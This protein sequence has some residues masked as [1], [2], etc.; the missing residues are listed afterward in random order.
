MAGNAGHAGSPTSAAREI[1]GFKSLSINLVSAFHVRS[2]LSGSS[3]LQQ[4]PRHGWLGALT[5]R[6]S[7]LGK[8]RIFPPKNQGN[9]IQVLSA[10]CKIPSATLFNYYVLKPLAFQ[11]TAGT[12]GS[13]GG[14]SIGHSF[15]RL[16][17]YLFLFLRT[18]LSLSHPAH[19]GKPSREKETL[20][21][22][23]IFFFRRITFRFLLRFR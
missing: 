20:L 9:A 7:K 5:R 16:P 2:L 23:E 21:P 8:L 15:W 12:S 4:V 22:M 17:G 3:S 1:L 19:K 14:A 18:E 13:A 11:S 10:A 6:P